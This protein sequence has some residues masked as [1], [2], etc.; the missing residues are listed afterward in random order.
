LSSE[1]VG[2]LAIQGDFQLHRD[3]FEKLGHNTILVRK[4]EHLDQVDRL[5]IPGGESTTIQLLIDK[6]QLREPLNEFGRTKPIW[7][8]CAGTILL[9]D[10]VDDD[11]IKPLRLI[12]IE[13]ARNAYG[14]QIN[15]FIDKGTISLGAVN[16]AFEMVFIRA[17]KIMKVAEDV[18]PIGYLR[19][20]ITA[21]VQ[22]SVLVTTFH[23]ELTDDPALH[24]FFLTL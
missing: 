21:A 22:G 23:P 17:P 4:K 1:N 5:V 14:R 12:R 3:M 13:V 11:R 16:R 24:E 20:E 19:D 8:T 6:Y 10:K 18:A 7:G 9:S 2:I 15:S